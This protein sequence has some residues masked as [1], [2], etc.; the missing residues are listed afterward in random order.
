MSARFYPGRF[1][2]FTDVVFIDGSSSVPLILLCISSPRGTRH[3]LFL[4][5]TSR[6]P[7]QEH[8]HLSLRVENREP[9][10]EPQQGTVCPIRPLISDGCLWLYLG[11]IFSFIEQHPALHYTLLANGITESE[12]NHV[13]QCVMSVHSLAK[14]RYPFHPFVYGAGNTGNKSDVLATPD[15]TMESGETSSFCPHYSV[16]NAEPDESYDGLMEEIRA[17]NEQL[18]IQTWTLMDVNLN[19]W[20]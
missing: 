3:S 11:Q 7:R 17:L 1:Y 6:E 8:G 10:G 16:I 4:M 20:T 2:Q 18:A 15:I 5:V 9:Q 13:I 19:V 14:G 12:L